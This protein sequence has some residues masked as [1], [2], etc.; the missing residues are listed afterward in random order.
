MNEVVREFLLETH[1]NL[2]QLD[3]DLVTLEKDSTERETLARVFRSLHTVKGTAGFLGLP[4]LQGVS[5][6]AENLLSRLRAGELLFNPD[7]ASA[8]LAVV[9]AIRRMLAAMEAHQN[10]GQEDFS[11][12]IHTLERL[13][14][15][16]SGVAAPVPV[17]PSEPAA[18]ARDPLLA[19]RAPMVAP[20]VA[21]TLFVR[22]PERPVVEPEAPQPAVTS[23]S[24]VRP[25]A[26][27]RA[28]AV[29]DSAIR[30]DVGLLDKLMNLV[31]ELV[32]ARNQIVQFSAS[33]ADSAFLGTVQRFN[34]LTTELQ[35][36]VMKTRMQ[37]IGNIWSKFPRV[38]RDLA[39]ACG[40][41][42]RIEM[43]GKETELDKTII[44]AIRDP[45]THLVRNAVDHGIESPATRVER[46][47]P[48]E[49][50]LAL[51]ASHESGKVIIEIA[52]DGGG[53]DPQRVRDKAIQARVV[54][55][56][57]AA[58]LSEREL[59][60]LIFL[61]GFSTADQVTQFSGRGVGMDVVRTNIEK[62]G[63]TVDLESRLGRG[64]TVKM[65][66]PLTLA[67]IPALTIT[68]SGDRYAIPQVNL[69]ELVRLEGEQ[70]QRGVELIHG[71][72]VY[73]LRGNLL[74]LVYLDRQLQV[75]PTRAQTD[76]FNIVIL[77]ADDRQFGLVVDDIH[78]TEEIVVKPL[79]KQLKGINVFAG[80]T[81]MGDGRVA[82][83]LDVLGLA[84][85]ANVIAGVRE[86]ALDGK[87][88]SAAGPTGD[89]QTVLL[90]TTQEGGRMA[91]PLA[92]VARLEEFPRSTLERVGAQEVVQYR[93]EI[94]PLLRVGRALRRADRMTRRGTGR[95]QRAARAPQEQPEGDT[96][97][98]VVHAGQGRQ[99]GLVVGAI[100]DIVEE[101][102]T[103]R[104]RAS[105]P[106]VLFTAVIQ[107]R[108]TEFLDVEG[109]IRSVDPDFFE[110]PSAV[111][112]QP[113]KKR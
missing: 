70:A 96:V 58:R 21:P 50:R 45:L 72:P 109:L 92:Q 75:E 73:R 76:D 90:F 5:H 38:V 83:I 24:G 53:I 51:H 65:K 67:I 97:S 32:L 108:V 36:G 85:R 62:I 103:S 82:L 112:R 78:D 40:K 43:E 23:D 10:E 79:Q 14:K 7:I 74:P 94:L 104:S 106:G 28:A 48:V 30:V 27:P 105:R 98:V 63:G 60:N 64:T 31:G 35:A 42:V 100:L 68:S 59:L 13:T 1:E 29:S 26:E 99:V 33:Q 84:Q 6:A 102:I 86:R 56:E 89:R 39:V 57:Q 41:Q 11:G 71:T 113:G 110:E 95:I 37:P 91:I 4:K 17:S 20:T 2:A 46:G 55:S 3:L 47:K 25:E 15:K 12:L 69:L 18:Q 49:G 77:Q 22:A 52:D 9:D 66:I 19:L 16:E 61:P 88:A 81:I 80:A 34:L 54:S 87:A 8:L 111:S 44:E 107:E 93:G 101:T